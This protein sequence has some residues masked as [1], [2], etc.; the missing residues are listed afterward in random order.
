MNITKSYYADLE[1]IDESGSDTDENIP[2]LLSGS[3]TDETIDEPEEVTWMTKM[4]YKNISEIPPY[5]GYSLSHRMEPYVYHMLQACEKYNAWRDF[6]KSEGL[7]IFECCSESEFPTMRK[8]T[9]CDLVDQDG[10]SGNSMG[11]TICL[12]RYIIV[13]GADAYAELSNKHEAHMRGETVEDS[14]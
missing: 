9:L 11:Y 1:E 4:P 8:V 2:E 6:A 12:T 13:N 14:C 10:H 7:N 3:D 5:S